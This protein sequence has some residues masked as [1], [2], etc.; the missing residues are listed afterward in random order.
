[1]GIEIIILSPLP[2]GIP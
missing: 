1:V 2:S